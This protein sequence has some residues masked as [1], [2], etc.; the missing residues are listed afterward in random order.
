MKKDKN[1]VN[2]RLISLDCFRGI[3]IFFMILAN[4]GAGV[5]YSQ[6][7]HAAWHGWS[8]A[9]TIFP[10]FLWIMGVSMIFS[11]KKRVDSGQDKTRLLLHSLKRSAVIF[12]LGILLNFNLTSLRL[13]GVLQKI[14]AC[15]FIASIIVLY[16]KKNRQVFW[17]VFFLA[18]YWLAIIFIPVPGYGAGVLDQE[19]NAITYLDSILLKGLLGDRPLDTGGVLSTVPAI[20]SVLFGVLTGHLLMSKRKEYEKMKLMILYGI[21]L[22]ILAYIVNIWLPINK[23][24]WTSSFT[25]LMA[26]LASIVF[27]VIYWLADIKQYRCW[28]TPAIAFGMNA[29]ALYVLSRIMTQLAETTKIGGV[30]IDALFRLSVYNLSNNI[31]QGSGIIA[32][33][34]EWICEKIAAASYLAIYVAIIYLIAYVSYKKKWFIKV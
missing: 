11:F 2:K 6:F 29:I 10:F 3:T 16:A 34:S 14:A 8:F 12:S 9:D 28:T 17:T 4:N 1:S 5:V 27:S 18:V 21:S 15:Y 30:R 19:G 7:G 24:L 22:V 23:N 20:S 31:L 26:G 32:P 33:Y 25:L 13:A